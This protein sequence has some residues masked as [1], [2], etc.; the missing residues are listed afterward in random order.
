MRCI[1]AIWPAGPPKLSAATRSHVQKASLSVTPWLGTADAS[2]ATRMGG[3]SSTP[4]SGLVGRPVVR[5]ASR[6]AAPAVE[7]IVK[8]HGRFQL[9]EIVAVHARVAK[10]RGKEA[11]GLRREVKA[12]RVGTA[13][14]G[15][16]VR[17]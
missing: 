9:L 12:R 7:R 15:R 17:Q 4:G 13:H 10:G 8:A 16:Q 5:L 6:L 1:T 14:D 11:S 3:A 2:G